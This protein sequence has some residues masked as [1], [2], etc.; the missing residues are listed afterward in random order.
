MLVAGLYS[1]LIT[2]VT[3]WLGRLSGCRDSV[4]FF[5]IVS[6]IVHCRHFF[7]AGLQLLEQA[8]AKPRKP[9][10][11]L[12]P[13]AFIHVTGF[14]SPAGFATTGPAPS[15]IAMLCCG[16]FTSFLGKSAL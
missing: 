14:E 13:L 6:R 3:V 2:F 8:N 11:L 10:L 1:D 5:F 15:M 16:M 12:P 7:T 4:V 9:L